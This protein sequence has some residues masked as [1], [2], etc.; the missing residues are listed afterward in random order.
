MKCTNDLAIKSREI[1]ETFDKVCRPKLFASGAW[2]MSSY[3]V[4][5]RTLFSR[6]VFR[7]A[8]DVAY[9]RI[10]LEHGVAVDQIEDEVKKMYRSLN[11]RCDP[12]YPS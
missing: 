9:A 12:V 8:E 1:R 11:H 10:A 2:A 5:M 4:P 3:L 6:G 7:H